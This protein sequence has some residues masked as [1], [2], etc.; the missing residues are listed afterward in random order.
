MQ[1]TQVLQQQ[2]NALIHVLCIQSL[3]TIELVANPPGSA[4]FR[5]HIITVLK[6]FLIQLSI[7]SPHPICVGAFNDKQ[8][9]A[10]EQTS[11][12]FNRRIL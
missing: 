1:I 5:T 2:F 12:L 10:L 11:L 3:R 9:N 6:P 8:T 7:Y 4:T